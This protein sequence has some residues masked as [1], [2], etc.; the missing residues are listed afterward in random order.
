M[1]SNLARWAAIAAF[2][3]CCR[4]A[5]ALDIDSDL[6]FEICNT[7]AGSPVMV[8]FADQHPFL[9]RVEGRYSI[10]PNQCDTM[11][12]ET[13]D[14]TKHNLYFIDPATE[15]FLAFDFGRGWRGDSYCVNPHAKND[16]FESIL[17]DPGRAKSCRGDEQYVVAPLQIAGGHKHQVITVPPFSGSRSPLNGKTCFFGFCF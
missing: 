6:E 17:V 4:P 10:D 7:D 8:V 1:L 13:G 3:L 5:F 9:T 11:W 2:L 16:L 12:R 15:T 14:Y